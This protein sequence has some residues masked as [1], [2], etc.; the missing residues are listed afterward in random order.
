[1]CASSGS[2]TLDF[3]FLGMISAFSGPVRQEQWVTLSDAVQPKNYRKRRDESL[4][5]YLLGIQ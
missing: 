3:H 2:L 4:S 1:M 5:I